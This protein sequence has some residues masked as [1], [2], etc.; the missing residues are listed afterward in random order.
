M[1]PF[2]LSGIT[3]Q[4]VVDA[5]ISSSV[6]SASGTSSATASALSSEMVSKV[7]GYAIAGPSDLTVSKTIG[8]V[9]AG[10]TELTISKLVGYAI[11]SPKETLDGIATASGKATCA[12]IGNN[13]WLATATAHGTSTAQASSM[14][15]LY[16]PSASVFL[17]V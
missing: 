1:L 17:M 5:V 14:S 11:V 2:I 10:P 8:Y 13:Y 9:L 12:A 7:L 6:A 15:L 3:D 16:H 4:P